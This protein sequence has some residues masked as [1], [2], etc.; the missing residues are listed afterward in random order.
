MQH[1]EVFL[2]WTNKKKPTWDTNHCQNL[3]TVFPMPIT[4]P[5]INEPTDDVKIN[6]VRQRP[7]GDGLLLANG[8]PA[9]FDCIYIDPPI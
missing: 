1:D 3:Q 7:S 5:L 6:A 8:F 9:E 2:Q 4:A